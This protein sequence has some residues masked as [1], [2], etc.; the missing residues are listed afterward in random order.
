MKSRRVGSAE[1]EL[2]RDNTWATEYWFVLTA[3][4]CP[5]RP[6]PPLAYP[7]RRRQR[8]TRHSQRSPPLPYTP[9]HPPSHII[10]L[11][12]N[13]LPAYI[14]TMASTQ[15]IS[16]PS[17]NSNTHTNNTTVDYPMASGSY[18]GSPNGSFNPASYTKHFLGSPISWRPG[19]LGFGGRSVSA[20]SPMDYLLGSIEYVPTTLIPR[21]G[22][23]A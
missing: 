20:G 14:S 22:P 8:C 3:E 10:Q 7:R 15:P 5:L 21:T 9:Q 17:A 2:R 6:P 12:S 18:T 23:D 11:V 1:I 16:L 4:G 19:S 13:T